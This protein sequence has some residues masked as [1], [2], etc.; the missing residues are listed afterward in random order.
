M[1]D[2]DQRR[3]SRETLAMVPSRTLDRNIL[4]RFSL[5]LSSQ[6]HKFRLERASE[7]L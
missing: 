4:S 3:L 5:L 6:N 2:G 1:G 7:V